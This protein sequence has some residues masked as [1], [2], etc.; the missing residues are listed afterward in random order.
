MKFLDMPPIW[1]VLFIVLCWL[2][3]RFVPIGDFGSLGNWLGIFLVVI[4]IV[5]TIASVREF[6]TARTSIIPRET[7]TNII[8]TGVFRYSRNPIYLADALILLGA[9]L[10]FDAVA[11]IVLVPLF[12][13]IIQRR[14]IVGEENELMREFPEEFIE[15]KASVRRWL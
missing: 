14:F 9:G 13:V 11:F 1:L 15:Y 2:Q 8:R 10:W 4:G 6:T 7:P 5:I 3:A 12:V